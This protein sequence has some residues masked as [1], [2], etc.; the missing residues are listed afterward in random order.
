MPAPDWFLDP[1]SDRRA[2]R[3]TYCFDVPD[4]G[5]ESSSRFQTLGYDASKADNLDPQVNPSGVLTAPL[6]YSLVAV[7]GTWALGGLVFGDEWGG[8]WP[9][10]IAI[11]ER[12]NPSFPATS[13][14]WTARC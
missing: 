8:P 13:G 4:S 2:P 12:D 11:L 1:R 7:G 5:C 3:E 9:Q 14:P 10:L 6:G